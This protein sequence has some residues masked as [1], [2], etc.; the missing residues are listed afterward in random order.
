MTNP[1][2]R[3]KALPERPPGVHAQAAIRAEA[4]YI[5]RPAAV[6]PVHAARELVTWFQRNSLENGGL[7]NVGS[8]TGIWQRYDKV[9]NGAFG[10]RTSPSANVAVFREPSGRTPPSRWMTLIEAPGWPDAKRAP[11]PP[12]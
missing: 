8:S 10:A 12:R 1:L 7:W 3:D 6:I 4:D 11:V 9:W 5:I 2:S